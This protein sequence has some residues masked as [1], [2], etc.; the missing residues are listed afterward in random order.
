MSLT[1]NIEH[2]ITKIL[3][4]TSTIVKKGKMIFTL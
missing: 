4:G 2:G 3:K 1:T